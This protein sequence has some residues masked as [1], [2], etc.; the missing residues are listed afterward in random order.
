MLGETH[1]NL[2]G[3]QAPR[4]WI[5]SRQSWLLVAKRLCDRYLAAAEAIVGIIWIVVSP[6]DY[7][8][9]HREGD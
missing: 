3:I 4:F 7:S 6:H 1:E 9:P 2:Q 5:R 8:Q